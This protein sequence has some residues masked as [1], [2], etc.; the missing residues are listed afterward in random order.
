MIV[1]PTPP[2]VLIESATLDRAEA[3]IRHGLR[4]T[5]GQSNLEI[6]Y[7][8]LSFIKADQVRFKYQLFGQDPDWIEAGTRR[9]ANYSYLRPGQ[10]TFRVMAANSDGVWN[11][12][13]AQ[14]Q[15]VVLP[16]FY[17]TWWFRLLALLAIAGFIGLI[18]KRRLD[19]ANRARRAQEAFS[20]QLIDS[21][22][23]ERK[24]IAAELHDS[25]GQN[26]LVI[27]NYALMAL[28]TGNGENP[29][30]EHVSEISEAATLSIE[31]VRQIAHNLRPYQLERLGL[32]N[33]LQAMLR[34]IANASDIG[35]TC[36]V[37]QIDG[38]LSKEEEISLYRIVQEAINNILKH[39]GASEAS[40][41]IKR[42]GD[43]IQVTIADDGRGFM[44][45]PASQAELQKRGFGL[46]GSAERVR[47]LGGTQK[48]QTAPGQGT[49]IHI[50]IKTNKHASKQ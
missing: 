35:F 6:S 49:T 19:R 26:L 29:M 24:R 20:R 14:L 31:E 2:P 37:D 50:I 15:V 36:E 7:T 22:E 41:R 17:Q 27:K 46:T 45:E 39:S 3:D 1:N 25:L 10:Y 34:Q 47:M 42:A 48:I 18:F 13:G 5:P 9:T 32:T 12:E 23:Q 30:R 40:I 38:L 11:S 44:I 16:A 4:V 33:T 28:N 43:E 21:Q 8:A